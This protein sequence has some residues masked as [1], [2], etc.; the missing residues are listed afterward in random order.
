LAAE[1]RH[2]LLREALTY[3]RGYR[4]VDLDD[5]FSA[6]GALPSLVLAGHQPELFHP[7]VWLKHF[8]LDR[9]ARLNGAVAINLVVDSDTIKSSS[10]RVPTG[11]LLGI[12]PAK[13]LHRWCR[14][15]C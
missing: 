11:S 9:V 15:R 1:A 13:D 2:E 10:M 7:G 3:T 5:R 14:T 4:D 12:A 6:R 8:L